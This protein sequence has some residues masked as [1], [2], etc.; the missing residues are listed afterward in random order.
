LTVSASQDDPRYQRTRR[1]LVDAVLSLARRKPIA[2]ITVSELANRAHVS[3]S[4]FYAHAASPADLLA[5][6]LIATLDPYLDRLGS[7]LA[8][9]PES[10]LERWRVVYIEM[11]TAIHRDG[12][13]YAQV[14]DAPG[15]VVLARLRSRL[16]E[17]AESFVADFVRHLAQPPS[18]LWVRMAVSQH[19]GN[20]VAIIDS[21]LATGMNESPEEVTDTF[22][23]LAPPWL[24]VRLDDDGTATI[25]RSRL[26]ARLAGDR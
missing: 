11:L 15:S 5:E 22:I 9:H 19:V 14:F 23:S 12:K 2:Q 25:G 16:G 10:Y 13:V 1:A 17:A 3:R 20:T 8:D 7:L 24:L 26:L 6:H 18:P 21:W 4:A